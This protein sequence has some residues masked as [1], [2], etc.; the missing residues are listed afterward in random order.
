MNHLTDRTANMKVKLA[1][2]V[3]CLLLLSCNP[4]KFRL[5]PFDI[6]IDWVPS[7]EY[8]GFFYAQAR[9]FYR[10]AG[11]SVRISNGTG[12]PI[13]AN[14]L[15]AGTI[16]AGTTT[17]DNLLRAMAAGGHFTNAVPLLR[18]NPCTLVMNPAKLRDLSGLKGKII[19][20]N[21]A[22]SVYLQ[23][24][25]LLTSR[26]IHI[27]S[28]KEVPVGYGG[29]EIF[30]AGSVDGFLAY[31]TNQTIDVE[32]LKAPFKEMLLGDEG[33]ESYG[34]VLVIESPKAEQ[35]SSSD[36]SAFI[37]ATLRGYREGAADIAGAVKALRD[38]SPVLDPTKIRLAIQKID[39]LN[40]TTAYQL[41]HVDAWVPD[42]PQNIRATFLQ[43]LKAGMDAPPK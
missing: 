35:V 26:N 23:F 2:A 21:K 1:L 39:R 29:A 38:Y 16:Y 9:G 36:I 8:Y 7:S 14:Q 15:R 10:D 17:S 25:S 19:G 30:Q 13:V 42:V 27:N 37:K 40:A 28:F 6:T 12:A 11:L 4:P 34:T 20:T 32:I 31:T 43:L 18:F 41:D 22:T 3:V 33:L 5:R 24:Q